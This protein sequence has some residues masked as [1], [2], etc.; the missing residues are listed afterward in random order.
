MTKEWKLDTD[1]WLEEQLERRALDGAIERRA[2]RNNLS[3]GDAMLEE[4][5]ELERPFREIRARNASKPVT[6]DEDEIDRR[7]RSYADKHS[8]TYE[9]GLDAVIGTTPGAQRSVELEEA[10]LPV[11][12]TDAAINHRAET[13]AKRH[14][15]A[16]EV[17]LTAVLED[18]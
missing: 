16:Y 9:L 12:D 5:A 13:Y 14:N 18:A 1:K 11:D 8:T 15:C 3:Y 10:A 2:E 7:A 17:A 6:L 4:A